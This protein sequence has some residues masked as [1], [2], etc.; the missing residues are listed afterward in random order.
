M[1]QIAEQNAIKK[2]FLHLI[3]D[4]RD[5]APD[6]AQTYLDQINNITSN[7]YT[8]SYIKWKILFYG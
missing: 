3:T 4:G 6:S 1:A 5:V 2:C 7:N 8:N